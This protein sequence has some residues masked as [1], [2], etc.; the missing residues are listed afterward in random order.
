MLTK[1]FHTKKNKRVEI[2]DRYHVENAGPTL[3]GY[4]LENSQHGIANIIE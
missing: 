1:S 3:H 4:A 2:S